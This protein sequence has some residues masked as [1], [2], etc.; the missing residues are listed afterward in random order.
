MKIKKLPHYVKKV[1]IKFIKEDDLL[2]CI[3]YYILM[4]ILSNTVFWGFHVVYGT[5]YSPTIAFFFASGSVFMGLIVFLS[6]IPLL[7]YAIRYA[8]RVK[9]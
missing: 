8:L 6:T 7:I 5:V 2:K 1:V 3:A 9:I 4:Y